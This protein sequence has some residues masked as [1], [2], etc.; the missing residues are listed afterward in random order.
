MSLD[1]LGLRLRYARKDLRKLKQS[2]LATRAG[3]KQPSLSDLET[4]E[5]KE[6]SGPV[7]I[8]LAREL[9]VRPEWLITGKG[10]AGLDGAA[11]H[12]LQL[13]IEEALAIKKLR[14]GNQDW[15]RYVLGLAM[16]ERA[17][18][19]LLGK[20]ARE[21]AMGPGIPI[22]SLDRNRLSTRA[23]R[24]VLR[25]ERDGAGPLRA[26]AGTLPPAPDPVPRRGV[27]VRPQRPGEVP[28][29][30]GGA[31]TPSQQRGM[32]RFHERAAA[33]LRQHG[34]TKQAEAAEAHAQRLR[35]AIAALMK[36]IEKAALDPSF[37]VAKLEQLLKVRDQWEATEAR[38]AYNEAFAASRPRRSSW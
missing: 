29:L 8:A 17:E 14:D 25:L 37:D 38:N 15:R 33:A 30:H 34:Q 22:D 24:R 31:M 20:P 16:V 4:G 10:P 13:G 9:A 36:I 26:G 1:S 12:G 35:E 5:T 11:S 2:E 28:L 27:P 3:I 6:I 21:G 7:L 18:Q 32:L 23:D 19:D